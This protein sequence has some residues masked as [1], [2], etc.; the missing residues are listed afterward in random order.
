MISQ[1][2]RAADALFPAEGSL[3]GNVKFFTL[4]N[5]VTAEDLAEQMNRADAQIA[6]GESFPVDDIDGDLTA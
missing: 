5:G 3:V 2:Q 6:A 1:L 4:N